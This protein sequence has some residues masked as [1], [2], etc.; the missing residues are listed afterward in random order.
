M[1]L[2]QG[3]NLERVIDAD[4]QRIGIFTNAD[5]TNYREAAVPVN[6]E[7]GEVY[8]NQSTGDQAIINRIQAQ[9]D[10]AFGRGP[11]QGRD[12]GRD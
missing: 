11:E 1:G 8:I 9:V 2:M 4:D 10:K 3:L 6:L 12:D 5:A 7:S